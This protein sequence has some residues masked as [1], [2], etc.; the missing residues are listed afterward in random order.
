[1]ISIKK[2]NCAALI[3]T[4]GLI[5]TSKINLL[6]FIKQHNQFDGLEHSSQ[7]DGRYQHSIVMFARKTSMRQNRTTTTRL[8]EQHGSEHTECRKGLWETMAYVTA[9]ITSPF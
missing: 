7:L 3:N 2:T 5:A 1:M 8:I 9:Y 6:D 4:T